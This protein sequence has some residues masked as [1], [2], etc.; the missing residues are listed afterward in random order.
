VSLGPPEILVILVI[1]L[2]VFG[3][4]RLPEV[5][6]QI[7]KGV[8]ELRN[9]QHSIRSDLEDVIAEDASDGA[10]PAPTLPP[11]DAPPDGT[12]G[13]PTVEAPAGES[14]S[15]PANEPVP[16]APPDPA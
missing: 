16:P 9:F 4:T 2:L 5:G 10:E 11:V 1:A 12:E 15:A 6:R 14:A 3:P 7:G 13:V 8:R